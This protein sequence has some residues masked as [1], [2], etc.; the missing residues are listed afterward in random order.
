MTNNIAAV[1]RATKA[2]YFNVN[3]RQIQ[4]GLSIYIDKKEGNNL[5]HRLQYTRNNIDRW[6]VSYGAAEKPIFFI[7]NPDSENNCVSCSS[8]IF[9]DFICNETPDVLDWALFHLFSDKIEIQVAND[10]SK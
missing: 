8:E 5:T 6:L 7:A 10:G 2:Q 9:L 3:S 4:D 1:R